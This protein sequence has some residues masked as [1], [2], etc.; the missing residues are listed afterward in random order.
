MENII[1]GELCIN[2]IEES[3]SQYSALLLQLL[4]TNDVTDDTGMSVAADVASSGDRSSARPIRVM[5][6]SEVT[7]PAFSLDTFRAHFR[8]SR[9]TFKVLK[10][11]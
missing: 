1:F 4:N 3:Q 8:M 7:V 10:R 5:N 6:F 2:I 11:L 9:T